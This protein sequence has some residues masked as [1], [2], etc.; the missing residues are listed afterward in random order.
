M[1]IK[2][3]CILET[4]TA[5]ALV[6]VVV[7]YELPHL[8]LERSVGSTGAELLKSKLWF[9]RFASLGGALLVTLA[10]LLTF[11]TRGY[12]II[13]LIFECAWL[14]WMVSSL[15]GVLSFEMPAR[16]GLAVVLMCTVGL[17]VGAITDL[18]WPVGLLAYA[19]SMPSLTGWGSH[20]A[21]YYLATEAE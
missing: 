1:T 20:R 7:A 12:Y 14:W 21:S 16:P 2:A 19:Q 8:W 15:M 13:P 6:P 11:T 3:A 17:G 4:C 9:S 18:V 5:S 10:G